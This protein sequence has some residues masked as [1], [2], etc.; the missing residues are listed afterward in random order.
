MLIKNRYI[1][2]TLI[3]SS[4]AVIAGSLEPRQ[5]PEQTQSYTLQDICNRLDSGKDGTPRNLTE[6]S[7]GPGSTACTLNE[8][9][10]NAPKKDTANGA[11]PDDVAAGKKYW[12]LT[13]GDWGIKT[14]TG[15]GGG[16]VE[17]STGTDRFTDNNDGT[18][19]DNCTK[20][21]WLKN[22]NCYGRENWNDAKASAS[23]LKNGICKLSDNSDAGDWHLPSLNELQSL[24]DYSRYNLALPSGHPFSGVQS[25]DY[26]SAT[27]Y[28]DNTSNAWSV[29]LNNGIV[30]ISDKAHT[31][32]VWP[33]R[34]RH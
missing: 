22:A 33:V 31:D 29:S 4:A 24:I 21:I 12:G 28:A 18:V 25:S 11:Q 7:S 5:P 16:G 9:M 17:C 13:D 30:T 6:P 20:L 8:V 14:G 34:S 2:S 1:F 23:S 15:T 19:I 10:E 32:Y 3:F 26:W 27:T